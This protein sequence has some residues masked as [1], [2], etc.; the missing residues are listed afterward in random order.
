V[1]IWSSNWIPR[2]GSQ[3]PLGRKSDVPADCVKKVSELITEDGLNWDTKKLQQIFHDI[4]VQDIKK[5][6]IGGP[7]V[8]DCPAWNFTKNGNFSVRSAY[9]FQMQQRKLKAGKAESS[10]LVDE[11]KG[12][13]A[14]WGANIPGKVKIHIWRQVIRDHDGTLLAGSCHFFPSVDSEEAELRACEKGLELIK[15]LKLSKVIVELDS[16]STVV[17]VEQ[18]EGSVRAW[19]AY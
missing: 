8:C 9:H 3:R 2:G 6:A 14:L 19:A 17:K 1:D 16:A 7:N 18:R 12:W 5:V 10:T 11:H 13:L 4:D 15:R